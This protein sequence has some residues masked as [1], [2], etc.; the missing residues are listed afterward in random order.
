M[1]HRTGY[2][3]K[4]GENY[5][6]NWR[7]AG[8][9]FS[10]SLRDEQG[11][12]ITLKREAEL[13]RAKFMAGLA[14]ADEREILQ[15]IA[16]R[17]ENHSKQLDSIRETST[18]PLSFTAAWSAFLNSDARKRMKTGKETLEN[19]ERQW[20][21]FGKWVSATY[22]E[23]KA[24]RD[25]TGTMADAYKCHLAGSG[26]SP[27]TVN[28]YLS[29]LELIFRT[30]KGEAQLRANPWTA[31]AVGRESLDTT[32]REAFTADEVRLICDKATEELRPLFALA[33]MTGLRLKDCCML[34]W[35]EVDMAAGEIRRIPAKTK[36]FGHGRV[37][38]PMPPTLER[39][40]AGFSRDSSGYVL[41]KVAARYNANKRQ[42]IEDIQHHI[43]ACGIETRGEANGNGR[44][45][46]TLKGFHSFRHFFIST[47]LQGGTSMLRVQK[48]VG[49][50]S[51]WMTDKYSHILDMGESRKA[52]ALLADT[53]Q[54]GKSE[55]APD[56]KQVR[57]LVET[58]AP[59]NANDTRA[60]LLSLLA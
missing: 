10:K 59:E 43:A 36:R 44:R 11:Q 6:V 29:A 24:L 38:I 8:R 41:P 48:M 20:Q 5:Y 42:L 4:R 46:P 56:L 26:R 17:I 32:G 25:V 58:L 60:K 52:V 1:K 55:A 14:V 34:R 57:A 53:I 40:L 21:H 19:Y 23:V 49:H 39:M 37:V 22:P 28:K 51:A 45:A 7:V 16:Q 9:L 35:A 12:P 33:A 47:T 27:N 31:D 50:S 30:L 18:P 13:A 2:L 3:F 54:N 15:S